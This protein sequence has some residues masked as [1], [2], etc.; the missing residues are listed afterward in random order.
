MAVILLG[1]TSGSTVEAN[2]T[3]DALHASLYPNEVVGSYAMG[4]RSGTMAAGLAAAAP[5]SHFHWTSTTYNAVIRRVVITMASLGTGFTAGVAIFNLFQARGATVVPSGGTPFTLTT[6]NGKRR[7]SQAT[8]AVNVI[9][10]PTTAALTAGTTTLDTQPL[11]TRQATISTAA[12]TVFLDNA[13]LYATKPG[14]YPVVLV[15]NESLVIQATV[16][17]T[18]T[19]TFGAFY[20]WDEVATSA[21]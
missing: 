14:E 18:G 5:V 12:V 2:P 19:W 4:A 6:N 21:F 20:E 3:H 8:T 17:A 13:E 9:A 15:A 10:V 16:P 7:A 11:A 1:G